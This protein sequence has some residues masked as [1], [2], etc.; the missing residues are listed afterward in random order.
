MLDWPIVRPLSSN[1]RLTCSLAGSV[2]VA[3]GNVIGK[4][5]IPLFRT[6]VPVAFTELFP[7]PRVPGTPLLKPI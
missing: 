4:R 3:F 2:T 6:A 7:V 1:E 5:D